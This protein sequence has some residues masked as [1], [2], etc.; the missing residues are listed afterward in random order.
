MIRTIFDI[1]QIVKFIDKTFVIKK[2]TY[3][4]KT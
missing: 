2:L 4:L 3:N 1:I